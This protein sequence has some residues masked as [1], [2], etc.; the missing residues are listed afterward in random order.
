MME[1]ELELGKIN[2]LID[3]GILSD[4]APLNQDLYIFAILFIAHGER[5]NP[6]NLNTTTP[7]NIWF[8]IAKPFFKIIY[9]I[10]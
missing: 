10:H 1:A 7:L 2:S 9:H 4:S 8:W 6:Q 5:H 3:E